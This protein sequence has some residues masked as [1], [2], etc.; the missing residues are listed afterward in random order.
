M[1]A[2]FSVFLCLCTGCGH[3][4]MGNAVFFPAVDPTRFLNT[5]A[6]DNLLR[7]EEAEGGRLLT[8]PTLG[9]RL[10]GAG[11]RMLVA[12]AGS[13]GSSYLLNH[14]VAELRETVRVALARVRIGR[15]TKSLLMVGLRGVGKTVHLPSGDT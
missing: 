6:R 8:A 14:T 9:E 4:L 5:G 15:S 12:S 10:Q 13:S 1:V 3:G 2:L 7:I 11:L